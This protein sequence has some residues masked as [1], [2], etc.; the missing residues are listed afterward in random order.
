MICN[1][2]SAK[3]DLK[4]CFKSL[5]LFP[6]I[7]CVMFS[8][9][10]LTSNVYAEQEYVYNI[11]PQESATSLVGFQYLY[12]FIGIAVAV[13]AFR[14]LT[15]IKQ[16][17]VY[18][19]IGISRRQ[20][21]KN[22]IVAAIIYIALAS[23][24]PMVIALIKN[25]ADYTVTTDLW[26]S[27]GYFA[28]SSFMSM[29]LGFSVGSIIMVRSGNFIEGG[30]YSFLILLSPAIILLML[31]VFLTNTLNGFMLNE[32]DTSFGISAYCVPAILYL[33]LL[34]PLEGISKN[35]SSA[36][37][38][39]D[40]PLNQTDTSDLAYIIIWIVISLVM[41]IPVVKLL[42]KRKAEIAQS[43]GADKKSVYFASCLLAFVSFGLVSNFY[44]VN[45]LVGILASL[46]APMGV[47]IASIAVIFRNK[48]D[49][50]QYIKGSIVV[51]ILSGVT[52]VLC[53]TGFFGAYYNAPDADNIEYAY[54]A[55]AGYESFLSENTNSS[56]GMKFS[57]ALYGKFTDKQDIE[58][59]ISIHN[60]TVDNLNKGN[61]SIGFVYKLKSG[62]IT[63]KFFQDVSDEG[64]KES[65]KFIETQYYESFVTKP[66]NDRYFDY[67]NA[68]EQIKD[69][70]DSA[71]Q[72]ET[73]E[74]YKERTDLSRY[75]EYALGNI[76]LYS[77]D[78]SSYVVLND[79]MSDDE[80]FQFKKLLGEEFTNLSVEEIFYPK[81]QAVYHITFRYN[82]DRISYDYPS[83]QNIPI[84][85]Q[86]KKTLSFLEK[87]NISLGVK[88]ADE[89]EYVYIKKIS[90]IVNE[91]EVNL[92]RLD[93]TVSAEYASAIFKKEYYGQIVDM[94]SNEAEMVYTIVNGFE[95][96]G[97]KKITDKKEIKKYLSQFKTVYSYVGND[98]YVANFVYKDGSDLL[99]YIPQ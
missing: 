96:T 79:I 84:Y 90:D 97:G 34:Q 24:L 91:Y 78:L 20:L 1:S 71:N 89:T 41:L 92:R 42:Q 10:I 11:L 76:Q 64:A 73:A 14:F 36:Y 27:C 33:N 83:Y 44:E 87:H 19:S 94:Q 65:F 99:T 31:E 9:S 56:D 8:Y 5:F 13:Q 12:A 52:A 45:K 85:P 63:V 7:A 58:K 98:G 32:I 48:A 28:A 22:R 51:F 74:Y 40:T 16:C 4:R 61:N 29:L 38:L 88:N 95:Q 68:S 59:I 82:E 62:K 25:K 50:K 46:I 75:A 3:Y 72:I 60:F 47:F 18:L 66:L 43:I 15:S 21:A 26:Q 93:K 37:R 86:M 6:L 30:I 35:I 23:I 2:Y 55:P 39:N 53:L 49:V 54:L 69:I 57:E 77:K 67:E 70:S 81:Q 17:N 80:V